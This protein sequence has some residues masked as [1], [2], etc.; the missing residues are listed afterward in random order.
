MPQDAFTLNYLA[1]ELNNLLVGGKIN[2]I[3][4][5]SSDE[6]VLTVYNKKTY[7]LLLNVNPSSPR[8]GIINEERQ[9][10]LTAPNFCMLLRKHLLSAEINSISLVG[11]DRIIKIVLTSSSEFFD[12]KEK[13]LYIELM[14]RYSNIILT[15]NDIVLGG[16][17]GV[18]MFDDGVRPLI[19]GLQ[20]VFPPVNNKLLPYD[21]ILI[22]ILSNFDGENLAEF[23]TK[24]V[25]GLALST[26]QK[27][28]EEF[29]KNNAKLSKD[30]VKQNAEKFFVF[31]NEFLFNS[32]AQPVVEI[33]NNKAI[34]VAV[35]PYKN[36]AEYKQFETIYE[37]EDYYHT[38]KQF[39]KNFKEKKDRA[40]NVVSTCLKKAKKRLNAVESRISD[41]SSMEKNKLYGELLIANL[42]RLKD[43]ESKADVENYY[44]E[45]TPISIPLDDRI[46]VRQNAENYFK[47]YNKQKRSLISL[48]PQKEQAEQEVSYF[49]RLYEFITLS[50]DITDI[51]PILSE[52]EENGYIKKQNNFAKKKVEIKPYRLY[53]VDNYKI[54]VGRNNIENDK[55][56]FSSKPDNIWIHAKDYHSSHIIIE[57]GEKG[58]KS[59]PKNVLLTA[60][61]ICAYYSKGRDAGKVDI[62]VAERKYVKKP[63]KTKAGFF[64]YS[65]FVSYTVK[66]AKHVEY[67][68]NWFGFNVL[69]LCFACLLNFI[70]IKCYGN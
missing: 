3:I 54:K 66:P 63:P 23:I 38:F 32:K 14:G 10:P 11:F 27:C 50:E 51:E 9:S 55:L 26:T 64:T 60:C 69:I 67:L 20:Y 7:R 34:D 43:G 25:Q 45:Y 44:E 70:M 15:E 29:E 17:R 6:I 42:Y 33:K 61:E 56:T 16:N 35:F 59:I 62:V 58:E 46:S 40:L 24:N 5:P 57:K 13:V 22:E 4:A 65:N 2:K 18:N 36:D 41:A 68:Q 31:F 1:K 47:K 48:A 39:E 19:V 52:L 49:E 12:A 37:A 30:D 8:I 21:E 28:I 53:V